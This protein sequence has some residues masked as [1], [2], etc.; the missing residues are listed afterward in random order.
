MNIESLANELL[1]S[2]EFKAR[3]PEITNAAFID[4]AYVNA[5]GRGTS[6]EE[7][8]Q[9]LAELSSGA[10]S[11]AAFAANL[12]E[13]SE[14]IAVGNGH[15]STNNF[16]VV[17]NEVQ[18]ER[19]LDK[20]F[21]L[22]VVR[23]LLGSLYD[24]EFSD[25][26]LDL[27][28]QD[29]INGSQ[30]LLSLATELAKDT[31]T[32]DPDPDPATNLAELSDEDFVRRVYQNAFGK[33]P[34]NSDLMLWQGHLQDG[35]ITR[36]ELLLLI[37]RS[38][39]FE[40]NGT[41]QFG[42]GN[43]V[44][45]T[46]A[47]SKDFYVGAQDVDEVIGDARD[48]RLDGTT[49]DRRLELSGGDGN[50]AVWGGSSHDT[51]SGGNGADYIL[52][53]AGNDVLIG[54][55]GADDLQGGAGDDILFIDKDDLTAGHVN[56]GDGV[57]TIRVTGS[58][59]V[60]LELKEHNVE[61]A[62]GGDGA[63]TITAGAGSG[64]VFISAGKGNDTV[65]GGNGN[66]TLHGDF[67]N[68]TLQGGDG[69]DFMTGGS[70][71]DT[72][73]GGA[74]HDVLLG[75]SG[76]DVLWG[77]DG[78]D[79]LEGGESDT[80][81]ALHGE[82]GDDTYVFSRASGNTYIN[83]YASSSTGDK[84]LFKDM[85][86]WD[87]TAHW[88]NG[89]V[90]IEATDV[91]DLDE[92]HIYNA[93]TIELFEF[94]K[95]NLSFSGW[96]VGAS[97]VSDDVINDTSQ[98]NGLILAGSG[99]DIVHGNDGDDHLR[100]EHGNDTLY[101]GDG[102]DGVY[103]SEGDDRLFGGNGN[104]WLDGGSAD[105]WD[106]LYGGSGDDTYVVGSWSKN[107]VI[108]EE[109]ASSSGDLIL[110]KGIGIW[111][112]QARWGSFEGK[113]FL[114]LSE[115][116][117]DLFHIYN[118]NK[119]E[120][121]E[122]E[123]DGWNFA[124]VFIGGDGVSDDV[125]TDTS[126]GNGLVI[127]GAG[128]DVVHGNAGRD[129]LRGDDGDD[130]LYGGDGDDS[131]FG[132]TGADVLWGGN[133][134]DVL[135]GSAGSSTGWDALHGGE[136]DDTYVFTKASGDTYLDEMSS[137]STGD[138]ILFRDLSIWDISAKWSSGHSRIELTHLADQDE[139]HIY[140]A[141]QIERWEFGSDNLVFSGLFLGQTATSDDEIN[142]TSSGNGLV[143]AGGGNDIVYG[144][145]GNDHL[146]GEG[147]NDTLYGGDGNDGVYG[148]EGDDR[149]FG[150]RGDD[151]LN[152]GS[153]DGW[154]SLYGGAGNDTYVISAESGNVLVDEQQSTSNADRILF[155]GISLID[156]SGHWHQ[157]PDGT[158]RLELTDSDGD[159]FHIYN[160]DKIE[161]FDFESNG[162]VFE[163]LFVGEAE[164]S[165][166]TIRDTSNGNG[167]VLAGGGNDVVYGDHGSD[168]LHGGSGNDNLHGDDGD[169]GLFGG[170]GD[171]VLT[172][173]SGADE[174]IFHASVSQGADRITDFELGVDLIEL[175]GAT[176]ADLTFV[177]TGSGTRVEWTNGSVELDGINTASLTEDQ[178]TF[179]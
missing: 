85:S 73:R 52:G 110:F 4:Q 116:D 121:W 150:D 34:S 6:M 36:G 132:G 117:G 120:R 38:V 47:D 13:S 105:N 177:D 112:L 81:N 57:D 146:R 171:D 69:Q 100:G 90:K 51:L 145:A 17:L 126:P 56:G 102:N 111:D 65:T 113:T 166:D 9:A 62:Y 124:G 58:E 67:G 33:E 8:A 66:D 125:I 123:Q 104:D 28:A 75:G 157:S 7:F 160:A 31:V 21:V 82:E 24:R 156:L 29:A 89:F 55:A 60:T 162:P 46:G 135:E 140:N 86:I 168:F 18:A 159:E 143:F 68:D 59:P 164:D 50:D 131:L 138:R 174:F 114:E 115:N 70:G 12:S 63:D 165:D 49:S 35:H 106:A 101:G 109:G 176:F 137:S 173:G 107:V 172:G 42:D 96:F 88:S 43:T 179:L 41:Q 98:G 16:D 149:L 71:D 119:I 170:S 118:A 22:D 94:E 136:G 130:K 78:N 133:G 169:D 175:R 53:G 15:M 147:G 129:F 77:G 40:T 87:F 97:E 61:A 161:L 83:E 2:D 64:N 122:F 45:I 1:Q 163:G 26:Q 76:D 30:S 167:L 44:T 141:N 178:F 95:D 93:H 25:E 108:D 5:L 144:N 158:R 134:A 153:A 48:N 128:N 127:A 54:G 142:D 23:K 103:G 39:E 80:W 139:L 14:H 91:E 32:P 37:A 10:T 92:L 19:S 20:S 155:Q 79:V 151:W 3:Y 11:Q 148:S 152:G 84:I 74:G 154:D 27:I 99:N 72:L